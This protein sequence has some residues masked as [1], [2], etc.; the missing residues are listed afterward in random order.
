MRRVPVYLLLAIMAA[1]I[2]CGR[3][4]GDT[5][6][7]PALLEA[8][9]LLSPEVDAA[10]SA[11]RVLRAVDTAALSTAGDRALYA[12]L[13]TQ[14]LYK[15]PNPQNLDTIPIQKAVRYYSE[16]EPGTQRHVHALTYAGA[17]AETN[18]DISGALYKYKM[19]ELWCDTSMHY[20]IGYVDMKIAN[21]YHRYTLKHG[22][23]IRYYR[24]AINQYKKA[25]HYMFWVYCL[26]DLG[27]IYRMTIHQDS[28]LYYL[29]I[30]HD[31]AIERQDS[32][33]ITDTEVYLTGYYYHIKDYKVAL[34]YAKMIGKRP[35][36][37]D[38]Y[39]LV[40]LFAA[41][42][43]A[44]LHQPDSAELFLKS[45]K[46]SNY[47]D[48]TGYFEALSYIA[49]ERGD[50]I[51]AKHYMS[52]ANYFNDNHI[53]KQSK[54]IN[55]NAETLAVIERQKY[56]E[57]QT[58]ISHK[59]TIVIIAIVSLI[60]ILIIVIVYRRISKMRE[61]RLESQLSR[62]KTSLDQANSQLQQTK[63]HLYNLESYNT[64]SQSTI[65]AIE[66]LC[67]IL[68]VQYDLLLTS[69]DLTTRSKGNR[70]SHNNLNDFRIL[71][72]LDIDETF[73]KTAAEIVNA[74]YPDAISDALQSVPDMNNAEYHL[75]LLKC[76][77]FPDAIVCALVGLSNLRSVD[78]KT[79]RFCKKLCPSQHFNDWLHA[80]EYRDK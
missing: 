47:V 57:L 1:A 42:S 26:S 33:M 6:T 17:A 29:T 44:K 68:T 19:A 24:Q 55:I 8:E 59:R 43:Y 12:L 35:G 16:A 71:P 64:E 62:L 41:S 45:A 5:V 60:S 66:R 69:L 56:D 18:G 32:F 40:P 38:Q 39:P 22:T 30:A 61:A 2:A 51:G 67:N 53:I 65:D 52:K 4:G 28:A 7:V 14:A 23:T 79:R 10:D 78:N 25:N 46:L 34:E 75:L 76:L 63:T 54:K 58:S 20:D 3:G 31:A 13:H 70:S 73:W 11:L 80:H 36:K 27:A 74:L 72:I 21:I 77:K 9:R 37:F 50:S 15:Q 49:D 48:S